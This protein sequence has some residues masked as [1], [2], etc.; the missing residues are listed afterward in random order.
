LD[1][2]GSS[3]GWRMNYKRE[4]TALTKPLMAYKNAEPTF[5]KKQVAGNEQKLKGKV[6]PKCN[7]D[8]KC[9]KCQ[10]LGHYASKCANWRVM[11]LRDDGETCHHLR[12]LVI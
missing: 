6:Q 10:G 12:M 5:M 11:I 3:S 4:R 7:R 2:T 9:F 1:C 8:I